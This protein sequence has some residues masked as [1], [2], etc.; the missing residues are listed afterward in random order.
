MDTPGEEKRAMLRRAGFVLALLLLLAPAAYRLR[1]PFSATKQEGEVVLTYMAWGNPQQLDIERR[2]INMFNEK[3]RREGKRIRVEFFMTPSSA[4]GYKLRLMY[5]SDCAPDTMRVDHYDFAS[6]VCKGYFLDITEMARDRD[7]NAGD[8]HPAAMRENYHQGRLYGLNVLFG[9]PV[10]YYNQDLF[11][12]QNVTDPY[13][14][15]QHGEWTWD[16]FEEAVRHLTRRE[17]DKTVQYGFLQPGTASGGTPP[18]TW[19]LWVWGQGG[20]ILSEGNRTSLLDSPKCIEAFT[21]FR[22]LRFKDRVAPTPA[23]TAAS[24]FNLQSGNV[25]MEMN[26]AGMAPTYRD[27]IKN[28]RWDIVPTPAPN[29]PQRGI[30][31]VT[32]FAT[33]AATRLCQPAGEASLIRAVAHW[34]WDIPP[35]AL[36]KGNQ[37]VIN[38][39]CK[40]PKEAWEWVKFM[41]SPEVE[42]MLHGDRLRRSIPTRMSLLNPPPGAPNE[43]NY[44]YA[45]QPFFHTDIFPYILAH[46]KELP[47]DGAWPVW[48]SYAER[49]IDRI[50]VRESVDVREVLL[51]AKKAIDECLVSEHKRLERYLNP[52]EQSHG[53]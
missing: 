45:T 31:W 2:I 33:A 12:Q 28:F 41:V 29:L 9:C 51:E 10:I 1:Q 34:W 23:D 16:A 37:L 42:M 4:Y 18:Y 52:R 53:R 19:F 7:L 3:C 8:F 6:M 46:S 39:R 32:E 50:F 14:L 47:I 35:Y 5:A 21:Y 30:D 48:T 20:E 17:G 27:T 26:F 36:V 38:S 15:W 22:N 11:A 25:A 40:H 13:T 43:L 49:Y 24:A 44:Q